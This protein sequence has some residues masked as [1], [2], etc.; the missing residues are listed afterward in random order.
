MRIY[1][2]VCLLLLPVIG[3]QAQIRKADPESLRRIVGHLASEELGGRYPGTAGDSLAS[4]FIGGQFRKAGLRPLG[5]SYFQPFQ[6]PVEQRV[7]GDNSLRIADRALKLDHD[8]RPMHFSRNG[9]AS[10]PVVYVGYGLKSGDSALRWNDYANVDVRGKCVLMLRDRPD[11]DRVRQAT[12]HLRSDRAKALLAQ[13][14]GAAAVI[15]V[16]PARD[17]ADLYGSSSGREFA[18][19]IPVVQLRRPAAENLFGRETLL[20]RESGM[21]AMSGLGGMRGMPPGARKAV[22]PG[23]DSA[24]GKPAAMMPG[25]AAAAGNDM[26]ADARMQVHITQIY[27]PTHNIAG[28]VRGRD[29]KLRDEYVIVGA[30]YDHLGLGGPHSGSR[31]PDTSAVHPGADDNASGVAAMLTLARHFAKHR[32][33]RSLLFVAFSAEEEGVVGSKYFTEHLPVDTSAVS[34]MFNFDMVGNLRASALTVGGSGT[35]AESD[36]LIRALAAGTGLQVKLSPA[37]HGPSDHA[38]FYAKR[39]PVFYLTTGA[40]PDYHTPSDKPHTLNYP[41]MDSVVRYSSAL[42]AEVAGR[43]QRLSFREAGAPDAEPLRAKFKVT[44]GLMP[45]VTG[46]GG[47]NGLRADI[48]VKG[49]PAD[50]AGMR[51]GDV[52]VSIDGRSVRNIEDYMMRLSQLKAGSTAEVCILRDG[53]PL[54]LKVDL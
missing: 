3:L 45:D 5:D 16:N 13:D 44:L 53:E 38:P 21:A 32:P 54:T 49:K 34:A 31:R 10:G 20:A 40:T 19:E 2:T 17:T 47:N 48:V 18:L 51:A 50:R 37:G 23:R 30:H 39:M 1:S 29:P 24:A 11:N 36:S 46:S 33:A 25:I 15:F 42:I 41:G 27:A 26:G 52:I 9:E 7:E 12:A 6:L 28:V 35:S 8:Y 22:T 4:A 14:M 43:P